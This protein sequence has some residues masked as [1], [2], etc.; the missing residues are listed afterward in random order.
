MPQSVPLR[1]KNLVQDP[2]RTS[3][4]CLGAMT[5]FMVFVRILT[6]LIL[7][8]LLG[9]LVP[10]QRARGHKKMTLKP[11]WPKSKRTIL[12]I[13][14]STQFKATLAPGN[15]SSSSLALGCDVVRGAG[16]IYIAGNVEKGAVI[17]KEDDPQQ[18]FGND[19][20]FVSMLDTE[21][22]DIVWVKQ[23]GSFGDDRIAHGGDIIC[24]KNT[25]AV[26]CGDTNGELYRR[27]NGDQDPSFSNIFLPVFDHADG[28]HYTNDKT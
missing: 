26:V 18:S 6:I 12:D 13:D 24:N 17:V 23:V 27:R 1:Q 3:R 25:N 11:L 5:E 15:D 22:G 2:G 8:T 7:F 28:A 16:C 20:V 9:R 14:W 19:D 21:T 10:L 4:L